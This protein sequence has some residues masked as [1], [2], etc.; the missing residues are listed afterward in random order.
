MLTLDTDFLNAR[1]VLFPVP[2]GSRILLALIGCGGT[3]SWLAAHVARVA[4]L[5]V[6]KFHADV[7]VA[8]IDFD[9]VEE[10]NC[11][12]QNFSFG[13][14]G[15]NKAEAL[16]FRYSAGWRAPIVA[17]TQPFTSETLDKIFGHRYGAQT[18]LI[19][20][21]DNTPARR[22]IL[23]AA[24]SASAWW[25]DCGNGR[26]SGQVLLGRGLD[27]WERKRIN[28]FAVEG[29]AAWL[30]LPSAV[31][32]NLVA[33]EPEEPPAENQPAGNLSCAELALLDAQS[34]SINA[35]IAAE[36]ADMLIRLLVT[37]DLRRFAAYVALQSGSVRSEYITEQ[38]LAPY[39]RALQAEEEK[40]T[41][42]AQPDDDEGDEEEGEEGEEE[43]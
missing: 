30:P 11:Y 3:G 27:R 36:A 22:E 43:E 21:V 24:S 17:H 35:R 31:F 18:V 28:P 26:D 10:K 32:P 5:L 4:N 19:G 33:D 37:G 20:C 38:A 6:E 15:L 34:L 1:R 39:L 8:F 13:E 7:G 12:R 41:A 9:V 25:L 2:P 42:P 16:A 14:V 40:Q 29:Y 23:K